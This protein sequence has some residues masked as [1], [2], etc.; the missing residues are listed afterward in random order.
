MRIKWK[1][2]WHK[3]SSCIPN[4]CVYRIFLISE[5]QR[6]TSPHAWPEGSEGSRKPDENFSVC[7]AVKQDSLLHSDVSWNRGR[8]S[9]S[10]GG[11]P[12]FLPDINPVLLF[13]G[14]NQVRLFALCNP[15]APVNGSRLHS[16]RP[17]KKY[18]PCECRKLKYSRF[19]LACYVGWHWKRYTKINTHVHTHTDD[20]HNLIYPSMWGN[21]WSQGLVF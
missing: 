20:S 16:T 4:W 2:D 10:E 11:N 21:S 7:T 6:E 5:I 17:V 19:L 13:R 15:G 1:D 12:C 3:D 14:Q 18:E 9:C 8:F